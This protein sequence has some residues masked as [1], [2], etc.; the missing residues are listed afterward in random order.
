MFVII[1]NNRITISFDSFDVNIHLIN[2][3]IY[4]NFYGCA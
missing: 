4:S 2:M 3:V 1:P